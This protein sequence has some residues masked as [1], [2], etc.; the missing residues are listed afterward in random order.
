MKIFSTIISI[1]L[2]KIILVVLLIATITIGYFYYTGGPNTKL[3]ALLGGL[4]TGLIVA[5]IQFLFSWNEH[6]SIEK[7][8]AL[9]IKDILLHREDR[10]FYENLIK[11][12]KSRIDVMGVTAS[13]F[14][15][16][17]ADEQSGRAETRVLLDALARKVKIRILVPKSEYLTINNDKENAVR[18]KRCFE[19]VAKKHDN[20][21]YRYF[22][23]IPAHSLVLV[24]EE[25]IIGPVFP[26]VRS[27]DTP[28]IHI[29]AS[30]PY[31]KK[32]L[33]Y[34]DIEWKNAKT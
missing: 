10:S 8:K 21:E 22:S 7:I 1:R 12:S 16:H 27:K 5:I 3:T 34:F 33:D 17:F 11:T 2:S 26:E 20:F 23:H 28:C 29:I 13:R 6:Q 30:S 19:N 32:Y 14:M 25:C 24:D 4:V 9:G 15:D 18:A 31:A